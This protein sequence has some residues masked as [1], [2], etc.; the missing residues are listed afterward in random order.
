MLALSLAIQLII[1]IAVGFL[2][3][4]IRLVPE[5]FENPLASLLSNIIIPC[6]IFRSMTGT[7]S[8]DE[9]KNAGYLLAV[10][11]VVLVI[12]FLVGYLVFLSCKKS[13]TGRILWFCF[14]FNNFTFMGIP[15][16]QTLFGDIGVFYL[17]VLLIPF[18]IVYYLTLELI[19][20]PTGGERRKKSFGEIMKKIFSPMMIALILGIIFY[21]AQIK[22]PAPI[23]GAIAAF[24]ACASPLG[25]L[26]CGMSIAK[27]DL[28][29]LINPKFAIFPLLRNIAI[30]AAFMGLFLLFGLPND[31][32]RVMV[33]FLALPVMAMLAA[34]TVRFNPNR[35]T[36]FMAA[37]AVLW[38]TVF[39]A[40]TIPVWSLIVDAVFK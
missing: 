6:L 10:A 23:D 8:L 38:S 16:M 24:S 36:Q 35:Q 26:M 1:M 9:L 33:I 22:M 32:S 4:K 2:I 21:L 28:K 34:F 5:E 29:H 3:V 30:P 13:D 27:Y 17:T 7:Y 11:A 20:T 12:L 25:M 39:S 14:P 19:L 31:I 37:G 40:A 18:R 15:V